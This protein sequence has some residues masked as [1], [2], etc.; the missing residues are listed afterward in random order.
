MPT[1]TGQS[2]LR[3][4]S[5]LSPDGTRLGQTTADLISFY[6]AT[7]IAQQANTVDLTT[8]L[9]NVG[10]IPSGTSLQGAP[11]N[12]TA[13]TLTVTQAAHANRVVTLSRAAGIALTLPAATGTG[14]K[15]TFEV[16]TTVT[17]NTTTI[18]TGVTGASSDAYAGNAIQTGSAG[19][20]TSFPATPGSGGS[21]VITLNGTTTGGFAGDIIELTDTGAGNWM[22]RMTTRITGTAATPFS[23]T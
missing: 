20:T 11:I 21:D 16:L 3:D 23:H 22:L 10:L 15:Y 14:N 12:V 17:S 7:P 18:T 9:V 4:L 6:G 5:D 1:Q 8:Q 13:A 2:L 19:A